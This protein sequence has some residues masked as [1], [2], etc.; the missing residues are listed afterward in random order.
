MKTFEVKG[1]Y[2]KN[3]K[4]TFTTKVLAQSEKLAREK[5]FAEFGGKQGLTRRH[6]I[7]DGITASK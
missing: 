6:I 4:H 5:T 2:N 7:I 1:S 3:G